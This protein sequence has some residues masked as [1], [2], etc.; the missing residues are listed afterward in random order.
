[1]LTADQFRVNEAWIAVRVNESFI[2]VKD[3]P[4]DMYVLMDAASCYVLGHV[5]SKVTDQAPQEKD[6]EALFKKAWEAKNQWAE[7][8]ILTEDSTAEKIFRK[9]AEKNS[10]SVRIVPLSDLEPIV[11]PLKESFESD[12]IGNTT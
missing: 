8:L 1:M 6:V 7:K 10:L 3:E 9:L 12:F 2:F 4:Y 11:G 5:L